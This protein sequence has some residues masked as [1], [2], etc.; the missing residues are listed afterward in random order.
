[1]LIHD[2]TSPTSYR[3]AMTVPP[4]GHTEVNADG[5]A[6]VYDRDGNP[7]QQVARPWAF[8]ATGQPQKT[9]YTVDD[10]G[11]LIQHVEPA[12][13]ARY[14]ILAD[15][16]GDST[17][18]SSPVYLKPRPG[19]PGFVGPVTPE[20]QQQAR[21]KQAQETPPAN[22]GLSDLLT[23]G[24]TDQPPATE[25]ETSPTQGAEPAPGQQLGYGDWVANNYLG[26]DVGQ[27]APA[28]EYNTPPPGQ[29]TAAPPAEAGPAA[30]WNDDGT[31]WVRGHDGQ[32]KPAHRSVDAA[33]NPVVEF[34][35]PATGNKTIL[36]V[37]E[38]GGQVAEVFDQDGT[39]LLREERYSGGT[40]A[41]G[42]SAGTTIRYFDYQ[43]GEQLFL[44]TTD[45]GDLYNSALS[46][47]NVNVLL[48]PDGSVN[49]TLINPDADY[50]WEQ[51]AQA[52][53]R[54]FADSGDGQP[55]TLTKGDEQLTLQPDGSSVLA[56]LDTDRAWHFRPGETEPYEITHADGSALSPVDAGY[57]LAKGAWDGTRSLVGLGPHGTVDTWKGLGENLGTVI[58]YLPNSMSDAMYGATTAGRPNGGYQRPDRENAL[59]QALTGVNPEYLRTSPAYAV[60][61]LGAIAA[62]SVIPGGGQAAARAG[63]S[64]AGALGRGATR[65]PITD[66]IA[67]ALRD[68]GYT[69]DQ[70]QQLLTRPLQPLTPDEIATLPKGTPVPQP[71]NGFERAVIDSARSAIPPLT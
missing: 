54:E 44:N 50:D 26:Q 19:D 41:D 42:S 12:A 47:G 56:N 57:D 55:V 21:A 66:A 1:M 64:L 18:A 69:P 37:G 45:G 14:P 22:D 35:D 53:P 13:D 36:T 31:G 15:P 30:Q 34:T 51:I 3:F 16:P 10:N 9:W 43:N 5:T 25:T 68:H 46:D 71:L 63:Q 38:Y 40:L 7:I 65:A 48:T 62:V 49:A 52:V 6:T 23:A 70:F 39:K 58:M 4:G 28:V 27:D 59:F 24:I 11:D 60:G 67:P 2:E 8:D 29:T 33:G 32:E 17:P 61:M 20:Q